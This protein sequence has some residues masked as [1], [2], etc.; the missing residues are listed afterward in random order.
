[1]QKVKWVTITTG[2]EV[3]RP[4]LPNSSSIITTVESNWMS[5]I[6]TFLSECGV[7][8]SDGA[9]EG[10]SWEWMW[11]RGVSFLPTIEKT[12]SSTNP[13]YLRFYSPGGYHTI[14][15]STTSASGFAGEFLL[16]LCGNP[17]GTFVF[18]IFSSDSIYFGG[19]LIGEFLSTAS[20]KK[21]MYDRLINPSSENSVCR[22]YYP[23]DS[24]SSGISARSVLL[25]LSAT[26]IPVTSSNSFLV[27]DLEDNMLLYPLFW[28]AV[29]QT[30][31]TDLLNVPY[32]FTTVGVYHKPLGFDIPDANARDVLYQREIFINGRKFLVGGNSFKNG[33]GA[34]L[35][36]LDDDDPLVSEEELMSE[37]EAW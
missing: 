30:G 24:Q 1:M 3:R 20:G 35:I 7:E 31:Y 26:N 34:P 2:D 25:T 27:Y 32:I 4:W 5:E 22:V 12:S 33:L 8:V 16:N 23:D 10:S 17:D 18:R 15:S 14:G 11:I 13:Y 9:I 28:G 6:A 21:Y 36:A 19:I 29:T 37:V